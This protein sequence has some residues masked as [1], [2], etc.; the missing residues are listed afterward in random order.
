MNYTAE[1]IDAV[2]F[3]EGLKVHRDFQMD[4]K[5]LATE[6]AQSF[7]DGY[8]K[9]LDDI[10]SMLHCSNYESQEKRDLA[11]L[12]GADNAIY[13]LCKEL[14][15]GSQDIRNM[16]TSIDEKASLLAARIREVLCGA[17]MDAEEAQQ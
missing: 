7:F 12:A 13:E 17:R 1:H 14:D 2:K 15:V 8:E 10:R 6:K 4:T 11:F 16:S 3:E 9:A 5:R